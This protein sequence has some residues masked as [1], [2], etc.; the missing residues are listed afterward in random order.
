MFLAEGLLEGA[1]HWLEDGDR[2]AAPPPAPRV[3]PSPQERDRVDA[4][5]AVLAV[6]LEIARLG[7]LMYVPT[8][9]AMS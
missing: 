7:T 6:Q 4:I 5:D 2:R 3:N 9:R 8:A 1:E